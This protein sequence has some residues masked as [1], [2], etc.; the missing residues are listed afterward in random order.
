ME[1]I[2]QRGKQADVQHVRVKWEER[3]VVLDDDAACMWLV[4]MI[5]R[6]ES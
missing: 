3:D 4:M 5:S 6:I 2:D 1:V